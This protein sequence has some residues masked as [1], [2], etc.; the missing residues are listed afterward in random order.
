MKGVVPLLLVA[1]LLPAGRAG[2]AVSSGEL[3]EKG[4]EYDGKAV[5]YSGEAIGEGMTRGDHGWIN[6]SDGANALGVWVSAAALSSI[7]AYGTY[8]T[9]GDVLR[10]RGT[11]HRAC[12]EH[13][14]D[15]DLHA[16]SVEVLERGSPTPR[17]VPFATLLLAGIFLVT[18]LVAFLLWRHREKAVRAR[19]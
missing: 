16:D 1:L 2:A 14:G 6:V 7:H 4:A 5:E 13:G 15:M 10:I 17:E 3:I 18:S 19:S 8:R 11:F 9:G 12:A